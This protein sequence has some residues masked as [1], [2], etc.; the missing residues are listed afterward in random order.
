MGI[1]NPDA[2][3]G[4]LLIQGY[5]NS[6]LMGVFVLDEREEMW[7]DEEQNWKRRKEFFWPCEGTNWE[8]RLLNKELNL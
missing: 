1:W 3:L 8:G 7:K 2:A 6:K 4:G 5:F